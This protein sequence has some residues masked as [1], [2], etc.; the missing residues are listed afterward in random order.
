MKV[1][2]FLCKCQYKVLYQRYKEKAIQNTL[3]LKIKMQLLCILSKSHFWFGIKWK[4][5]AL[6][7]LEESICIIGPIDYRLLKTD[8]NLKE[9]SVYTLSNFW[10]HFILHRPTLQLVQIQEQPENGSGTYQESQGQDCAAWYKPTAHTG[11]HLLCWAHHY[12]SVTC[13]SQQSEVQKMWDLQ[14]V[15]TPLKLPMSLLSL[16]Q[17]PFPRHSCHAIN[18]HAHLPNFFM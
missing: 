16:R 17:P 1:Q 12:S 15:S 18:L 14:H 9:L 7:Q 13:T 3:I 4:D 8:R 2:L 5:Y 6:Q 11:V 10:I